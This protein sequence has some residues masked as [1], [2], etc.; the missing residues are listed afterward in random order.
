MHSFFDTD[1][2]TILVKTH[3]CFQV[4]IGPIFKV[5]KK[6][7][8]GVSSFFGPRFFEKNQNVGCPNLSDMKN[9]IF[10][11]CSHDFLYFLEYFGV[12]K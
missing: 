3:S 9:I 8:D 4:D 10:L 7:L 11:R 1:I 5:F 6:F 2:G 12:I